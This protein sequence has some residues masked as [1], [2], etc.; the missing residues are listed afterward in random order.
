MR[1][2]KSFLI[3]LTVVIANFVEA[4]ESQSVKIIAQTIE[5]LHQHHQQIWDGYDISSAPVVITFENGH[6]YAF[7]LKSQDP[8]W[9]RMTVAGKPVLFSDKDKWG[10][11][12]VKMQS[13]FEIENQQAFVINI[14]V[15]DNNEEPYMPFLVFVHERFH[16]HQFSYFAPNPQG[17]GNYTDHLNTN[18]LVLMQ[19]EELLLTDYLKADTDA[20]RVDLLK[21]FLAVNKV[22]SRMLTLSSIL[23]EQHQQ[24]MEGLADYA[25]IKTYE[26][27]PIISGFDSRQHLL[28]TMQK[29]VD[30]DQITERAMKW[31]HY[32]VGATLGHALDF[33]QVEWKGHVEYEGISQVEI[34]EKALPLSDTEVSARLEKVKSAHD[35]AGINARI[36]T[37]VDKHVAYLQGLQNDFD[38]A[39]GVIVNL[40]KPMRIGVSGGGRNRGMFF[41]E[42][43]S[44]ISL[45]DHSVSTSSD[46]RW[47]IEFNNVPHLFQARKGTRTFKVDPRLTIQLDGKS[48]LASDLVKSNTSKPFRAIQWKSGSC[49][50][51]SSQHPGVLKVQDGELM[52]IYNSQS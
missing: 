29:Y 52:V 36:T 26:V 46:K 13:G 42:D 39:Q 37:I 8:V 20:A 47:K 19:L 25:S 45:N 30:S 12:Q 3:I 31:R 6:I 49:S 2:L 9:K 5:G 18:S 28:E 32:G 33:L 34:L 51:Q 22:R 50:F 21:D 48:Y 17:V 23:W 38:S 14:E 15:M 44:T 40:E 10:V 41:L 11:T 1:F 16:E 24:I 43:G 4:D 35:F 7:N 27:L